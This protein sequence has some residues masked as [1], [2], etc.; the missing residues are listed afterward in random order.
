MNLLVSGSKQTLQNRV[1]RMSKASPRD[2]RQPGLQRE[3]ENNSY[4]RY[5]VALGFRPE[6]LSD[7]KKVVVLVVSQ[8]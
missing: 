6:T 4:D 1:R 8:D 5:V 7:T 3:V 2:Q